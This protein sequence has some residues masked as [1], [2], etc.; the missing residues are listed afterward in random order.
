MTVRTTDPADDLPGSSAATIW[1]RTGLD[2]GLGSA[3]ELQMRRVAREV[4]DSVGGSLFIARLA[5]ERLR[6]GSAPSDAV[7]EAVHAVDDAMSAVRSLLREVDTP[8]LD[9]GLVESLR[10]LLAA[11]A[12]VGAFAGRVRRHPLE[13][14]LPRSVELT[15][16]RVAQEAVTN[17]ARH[18]NASYVEID[19]RQRRGQ[20][21]L[22]VSDD[23]KGFDLATTDETWGLGERFGLRAMGERVRHAGGTF[24]IQSSPGC[25]TVVRAT[26]PNPRTT[27]A[28]VAPSVELRGRSLE[29]I[30]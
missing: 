28:P 8:L 21:E 6:I 25:G 17:V 1:R 10:R 29:P 26:I 22:T 20:I 14:D 23:G 11:Y 12:G 16:Y 2:D 3:A 30:G 13:P 4:H 24:E 18:A 5:V 7:D 9:G 15:L 27:P 19:L